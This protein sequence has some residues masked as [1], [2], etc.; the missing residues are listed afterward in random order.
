MA[1]AMNVNK[2]Y[3]KIVNKWKKPFERKQLKKAAKAIRDAAREPV[4]NQDSVVYVHNP[5]NGV[6]LPPHPEDIFAVIRIKGK[7]VKVLLNDVV[8]VEKLPFDV[9]V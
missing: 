5:E 3:E 1:R 7:Q 2:E 6:A 8:K 9:G 4:Q